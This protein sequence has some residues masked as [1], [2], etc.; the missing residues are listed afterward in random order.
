MD[1]NRNYM[2]R[3]EYEELSQVNAKKEM[4]KRLP[5]VAPVRKLGKKRPRFGR[6][7]GEKS[8]HAAKEMACVELVKMPTRPAGRRKV[9]SRKLASNR[10]VVRNRNQETI[11]MSVEDAIMY[12]V[13]EHHKHELLY[14]KVNG[15]KDNPYDLQRVEK[16][17]DDVDFIMS[18]SALM[19]HRDQTECIRIDDWVYQSQLYQNITLGIS[20]FHAF[21][22]RKILVNWAKNT[23]QL[24][25]GH[26]REQL[27]QNLLLARPSYTA[28]LL[29]MVS[30]GFE[31]ASMQPIA[32]SR[33][34]K[35]L[36][37][38]SF[39]AMR[40]AQKM[41]LDTLMEDIGLEHHQVEKAIYF[42]S[43][44]IQTNQQVQPIVEQ[45][46]QRELNEIKMI[47]P[48][49]R[50]S[51]ISMIS[52]TKNAMGWTKIQAKQDKVLMADF[53]KLLYYFYVGNF[54]QLALHQVQ[55]VLQQIQ[56][57]SCTP[58]NVTLQYTP[59]LQVQYYPSE[60]DILHY[61]SDTINEFF[62]TLH[63]ATR[64]ALLNEEMAVP[65][66]LSLQYILAS[67][68]TVKNYRKNL[69]HQLKLGYIAAN[70]ASRAFSSITPVVQHIAEFNPKDSK[71]EI[72]TPSDEEDMVSLVQNIQKR[73]LKYQDWIQVCQK[74]QVSYCA[75]FMD[76]NCKP[77]TRELIE[78]LGEYKLCIYQYLDEI[79]VSSINHQVSW[80]KSTTAMYDERPQNLENFCRQ[81]SDIRNAIEPEKAMHTDIRGIDN[82][83]KALKDSSFLSS[84]MLQYNIM[85][86][87]VS[88][89]M[90]AQVSNKKFRIQT[91]PLIKDQLEALFR[92]YKVRCEQIL[93]VVSSKDFIF[94]EHDI[95]ERLVVI[96]TFKSEVLTIEN[97]LKQLRSYQ[98]LL[99][100]KDCPF[101]ELERLN[102]ELEL[103]GKLWGYAKQW[104]LFTAEIHNMPF[105][106]INWSEKLK[107]LVDFQVQLT[108]LHNN[109]E[110]DLGEDTLEE[111][112]T[113]VDEFQIVV[114]L[115]SSNMEKRHWEQVFA[116][117]DYV[118]Q[119][120]STTMTPKPN[121][122]P[123]SLKLQDLKDK[124]FQD[125]SAEIMSICRTAN[126]EKEIQDKY[127]A[128]KSF[129]LEHFLEL[130]P[131]EGTYKI[132]QQFLDH[133]SA[134][135]DDDLIVL[136]SMLKAVANSEMHDTLLYWCDE[137]VYFHQTFEKWA[138]CQLKFWSINYVLEIPDIRE[139]LACTC[140]EFEIFSLKWKSTLNR[141]NTVKKIKACL[142][143]VATLEYFQ[144]ADILLEQVWKHLS[145]YLQ[146]KRKVFA[147]FHFVSDNDL[148][149][150]IAAS[151][152]AYN[153]TNVISIC[154]QHIEGLQMSDI[155]QPNKRRNNK[156]GS[157]LIPGKGLLT[158]PSKR[159]K[160]EKN[161]NL[162]I[163]KFYG[164]AGECVE[165]A[166]CLPIS[167]N[168]EVWMPSFDRSIKQTIRNGLCEAIS[169]I[170]NIEQS[171]NAI[172]NG[173]FFKSA[174]HFPAQALI[175]SGRI[176]WTAT[177]VAEFSKASP[178]WDSVALI[179]VDK[180]RHF[181]KGL[182]SR[183]GSQLR[184]RDDNLYLAFILQLKNQYRQ[185]QIFK[186]RQVQHI[187]DFAWCSSMR[188]NWCTQS[189]RCS[190]LHSQSSYMYGSEYTSEI[191]EIV[192]S[193]TTDRA[194]LSLSV[195]IRLYCGSVLLG[196]P[197]E[198]KRSLLN[199]FSFSLGREYINVHC[200]RE[201]TSQ[202]YSRFL[203][204]MIQS[205][206]W[207][208]FS[209]LKTLNSGSLSILAHQLHAIHMAF[210]AHC[211]SMHIGG[212][213]VKLHNFV[214]YL[215]RI[216][217]NHDMNH[218]ALLRNLG[219]I[220]SLFLPI[221]CV[222]ANIS[223]L[224]EAYFSAYNFDDPVV[225]TRVVCTVFHSIEAN[226]VYFKG[227][228][229]SAISAMRLMHYVSKLKSS[230]I[231]SSEKSIVV[232]SMWKSLAC[233]VMPDH[234]RKLEIILRQTY[235][236][237]KSTQLPDINF[238]LVK[239]KVTE[240]MKQCC[241]QN[242]S[243]FVHQVSQLHQNLQEYP[244]SV[245][246][247]AAY[248]GKTE[249]LKCF[250]S[251]C[252][253]PSIQS[254]D[255]SSVS[256][257]DSD[258]DAC[259]IKFV[260]LCSESFKLETLYGSYSTKKA[261]WVDGILSIFVG[262]HSHDNNTD[263]ITS[264]LVLDGKVDPAYMEPLT[265]LTNVN[266]TVGL[267]NGSYLSLGN[268]KLV[269]ETTELVRNTSV[270]K[271]NK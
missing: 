136:E 15:K 89:L 196:R 152:R 82:L 74:L 249:V 94:S 165:L 35:D 253:M 14:F 158:L 248:S 258:T 178:N 126:R 217:V 194:I 164:K 215:A 236:T 137:L 21:Q 1:N 134:K 240:H 138:S 86:Q 218:T 48:K 70:Q 144:E 52:Q 19:Q 157:A 124:S 207:I 120:E 245:L 101:E 4:E 267:P 225:A 250:K 40:A 131:F 180:I 179:W 256:S 6:N 221:S 50:S 77:M 153:I 132:D 162:G 181:T 189:M 261:K 216:D 20:L 33:K 121:D 172:D 130:S 135:L 161:T 62:H 96:S 143:K 113:I 147:R 7:F 163:S 168:P 103:V 97:K 122:T 233:R 133:I 255:D 26:V 243:I 166:E 266:N 111:I 235:P 22:L 149:E 43:Q 230:S 201:T 177:C 88:K 154:Y 263:R 239:R 214:S 63:K 28:T 107:A 220:G 13:Q 238:I 108:T 37:S 115:S 85:H 72:I 123:C 84:F 198:G 79:L 57:A 24:V 195:A 23:K 242:I 116:L 41:K 95:P 110:T 193:P 76:V 139:N 227:I 251:V 159:N 204:G 265:N 167:S 102:Y 187:T 78:K 156:L 226:E 54:Y 61:F 237:F 16:D 254:N 112:S 252:E 150:I 38:I 170:S 205:D 155:V 185:I 34:E 271:N 191:S 186:D 125:F 10:E 188:Y 208:C 211:T 47:H 184:L 114:P 257:S 199:S 3:E 268:T 264:C 5:A 12:F 117:L 141:M 11:Q 232:H 212:H 206:L 17:D 197:G 2:L 92:K 32:L 246:V 73:I 56:N 109:F 81:L 148:I 210:A 69:S 49:W 127:Q 244:V 151:Q 146:E 118:P 183:L 142:R 36:K 18:K 228:T 190:I 90:I 234:K 51:P 182:T 45:Q 260:R 247:G 66:C 105:T 171:L 55:G 231:L 42:V 46:Y 64:F 30:S 200:S 87:L 203:I 222:Q 169:L 25:F 259:H 65:Y 53:K 192:T 91:T 44:L 31:V 75:K 145:E 140:N 219:T 67:D 71:L 29:Q 224:L 270:W 269:L 119:A 173:Q 83:F 213:S 59:Q 39:E 9:S 106:S 99:G 60:N 209:G 175:I 160:H 93:E 58:L 27:E 128:L 262:V 80:L 98:N 223:I 241:M 202:Q 174:A 68:T 176:C 100:I 104:Q 229:L 129:W 8:V